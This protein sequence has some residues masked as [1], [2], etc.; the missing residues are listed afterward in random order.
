MSILQF[1]A[2]EELTGLVFGPTYKKA[3]FSTLFEHVKDDAICLDQTKF[4][5]Q[6]GSSHHAHETF[7][8]TN[9]GKNEEAQGC[10]TGGTIPT[11]RSYWPG[12]NTRSMPI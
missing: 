2:S 10:S 9:E 11:P 1:E 5:L 6:V 7:F 3:L 4:L 8:K 12:W